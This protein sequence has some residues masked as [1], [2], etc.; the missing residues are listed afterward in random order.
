MS[1]FMF[2][3]MPVELGLEY[4]I[5]TRLEWMMSEK[6]AEVVVEDVKELCFETKLTEVLEPLNEKN[7]NC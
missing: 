3:R 7:A 1:R 6:K 5:R 2:V 4:M